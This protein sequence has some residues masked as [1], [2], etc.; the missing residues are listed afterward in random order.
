QAFEPFFT[1]KPQGEGAGLGLSTAYGFIKQSGGH[2]EIDSE[3]GQGTVVRLYLP[4]AAQAMLQA[5]R[6]FQDKT[7]ESLQGSGLRLVVEDEPA[8]RAATVELLSRLGYRTLEAPHAQAALEILQDGA[9]D[10]LIFTDV[11][12]PGPLRSAEMAGLAK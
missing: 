4:R 9:K 7:R 12:T 6:P 10:A 8:V 5:I 2:I 11:A 1:T 3:P